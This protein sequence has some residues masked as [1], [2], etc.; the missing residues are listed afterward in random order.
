MYILV[1]D[2]EVFLRFV[3]CSKIRLPADDLSGAN[4]KSFSS[5]HHVNM[6]KAVHLLNELLVTLSELQA[7]DPVHQ[8]SQA[9][10]EEA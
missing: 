9:T 3:V 5:S 6:A 10:N 1:V 4:T 2:I 8:Y 7:S